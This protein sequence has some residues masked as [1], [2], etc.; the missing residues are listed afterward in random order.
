MGICLWALAYQ[1][2]DYTDYWVWISFLLPRNELPEILWLGAECLLTDSFWGS[3]VWTGFTWAF[4]S[5]SHQAEINLLVG[6]VIHLVRFRGPF[7]QAHSG[8]WQK[9]SSLW[10]QKTEACFFAGWGLGHT[11]RYWRWRLCP[12]TWPSHITA[13]YLRASRRL[14]LC[15]AK[16]KSCIMQHSHGTDYCFY[17]SH[18]PSGEG[19]VEDVTTWVWEY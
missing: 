7:F 12:T 11:L 8:C 3:G 15:S 10:L 2:I 13:A 18:Q 19:T 6:A 17:R 16:I 1:P 14:P 4:C 5:G 9:L